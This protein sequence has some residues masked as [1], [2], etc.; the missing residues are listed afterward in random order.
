MQQHLVTKKKHSLL[1]MGPM[2]CCVWNAWK[3]KAGKRCFLRL[4]HAALF[5]EQC[6]IPP[7]L[8]CSLK[9]IVRV[10]FKSLALFTWTVFFFEKP[11]NSRVNFNSLVLY[12]NNFFFEKPVN[13][14]FLFEKPVQLIDFTHTVHVNVNSNIF[15][16]KN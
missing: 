9:W 14:F 8:H 3:K 10:N 4:H 13:S 5:N 6:S 16:K 7:Q 2:K 11:V 12:V 1:F 15:F